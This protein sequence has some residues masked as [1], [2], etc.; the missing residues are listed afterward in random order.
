MRQ[1]DDDVRNHAGNHFVEPWLDARTRHDETATIDPAPV[2]GISREKEMGYRTGAVV[3]PAGPQLERLATSDVVVLVFP[4]VL[5][6]AVLV[7]SLRL[8]R[9][10]RPSRIILFAGIL[11]GRDEDH[12]VAL[13]TLEVVVQRGL[14]VHREIEN[15]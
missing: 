1:G 6:D 3:V 2:L 9:I 10:V 11:H 8:H 13:V 12:N 14:L 4:F 5:T 15:G 7:D